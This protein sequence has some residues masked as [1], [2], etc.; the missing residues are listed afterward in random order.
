CVG[1]PAGAHA[2][3][4]GGAAPG[5]P[6]LAPGRAVLP[7]L[8]GGTQAARGGRLMPLAARDLSFAYGRQPVLEGVRF[9]LRPGEWLTVV[10]PN[11]A[12]KTTLLRCLLGLVRPGR[13]E[14]T[15]D[16]R[17][18][19]RLSRRDIARRLALLPQNAEVRFG[20]TVREVV[21]TGR[22]PHLGRF[23]PMTARD[24]QLVDEALEATETAGLAD[25][26]VTQLSGGE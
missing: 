22:T 19:A 16:C 10:G 9:D 21:A 13:G 6:H 18:L 3:R 15:L 4:A 5:R 24:H 20:F 25:R 11:G 23:R 8:A 26:P 7:V 12:G 1:G 2:D 14:V 17:P